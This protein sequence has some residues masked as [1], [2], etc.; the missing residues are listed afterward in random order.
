MKLEN[1]DVIKHSAAVQITNKINLLQRR[2]WN[3]LLANAYD[4]LPNQ[5]TFQV[6]V[7]DLK[8][9]MGLNSKND[10]HI[11]EFLKAL[12]G[13]VVEWNVLDKD[14]DEWS[15]SG[16]L[17]S[18]SMKKGI[19]TYSYSPGLRQ[20]LHNPAMYAR[21]SLSMQ[22]RFNSKH[23]LALYEL[24]VDYFIHKKSYGTTP[25]I[26]VDDFRK[27]MGLVGDKYNDF[28]DLNKWVIKPAIQEINDKSDL[29]VNVE[30]ETR[31]RKVT[32]LK[33]HIKPNPKKNPILAKQIEGPKEAAGVILESPKTANP[34]LYKRMVDYFTIHPAKALDFI[35]NTPEEQLIAN[36]DYVEKAY[37]SGKEKIKN[38]GA[39]TVSA[40]E[41]NWQNQMSIF[42]LEEIQKKETREREQEEKRLNERLERQ[43]NEYIITTFD[44]IKAEYTITDWDNLETKTKEEIAQTHPNP[45][46]IFGAHIDAVLRSKFIEQ[47]KILEFKAWEKQNAGEPATVEI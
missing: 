34:E 28:R 4:D 17:A 36:L 19:I 41:N 7:V 42:Q 14:G 3:I 45:K 23:S 1:K 26:S 22:N 30:L 13:C 25:F 8:R 27:L 12:I 15:A 38:L 39:Y 24:S 10:P 35:E 16:L 32:A 21:I 6:S 5:D 37:K 9:V 2:C 43:Y 11:K 46:F 33:L 40:I 20:K 44:K 47:G 18:V 31:G 29:Y